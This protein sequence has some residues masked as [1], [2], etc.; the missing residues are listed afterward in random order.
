MDK[1]VV[2]MRDLLKRLN[3]QEIDLTNPNFYKAVNKRETFFSPEIT[4]QFQRQLNSKKNQVKNRNL[5]I[6]VSEAWPTADSSTIFTL[7]NKL[8][9][10]QGYHQV[11][12]FCGL[13]IC[14]SDVGGIV[15]HY[16]D[17]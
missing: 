9:W 16:S 11:K 1:S 15:I 12:L 17:L 7:K 14:R 5:F 13:D 2:N 4:H 3:L 10:S 8:S 6:P